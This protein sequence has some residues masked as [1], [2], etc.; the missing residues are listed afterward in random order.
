MPPVNL[1]CPSCAAIIPAPDARFCLKCG[2]S[3]TP[4][5]KYCQN[6]KVELAPDANF[7][8]HCGAPLMG[9]ERTSTLPTN[10]PPMLD[11]GVRDLTT[12]LAVSGDEN[13][14]R[15][16]V[17]ML[18]P[19]DATRADRD[20]DFRPEN[21]TRSEEPPSSGVTSNETTQSLPAGL[22]MKWGVVCL[23]FSNRKSISTP[24]NT[25]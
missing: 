24:E 6:C 20:G 16:G 13:Q 25:G 17:G 23:S 2:V 15:H 22:F 7:C 5:K 21:L 10:Q 19:D 18:G 14:S 8:S 9:Q 4:P 11:Q 1:I 12:G 3:L